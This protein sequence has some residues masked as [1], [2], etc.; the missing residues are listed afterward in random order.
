MIK[1]IV[2]DFDGT[3]VDSKMVV[4]S[5]YNQI[6]AKYNYKLIDDSNIEH[7]K[8]LS[9]MDRMK[10]VNVPLYKVP[11]LITEFFALYQKQLHLIPFVSG[12]ERVL[13]K[14]K[15]LRFKLAVVSSN[16][17]K[18]IKAFLESKGVTNITGVYCSSKIFGKEKVLRRFLIAN[19]LHPS[20]VL[21]VCDE[22]RDLIACR[23]VN[24]KTIWVSWGYD[25][26]ESFKGEAMDYV[27]D[28]PEE[29]MT[30]LN[31]HAL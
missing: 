25:I 12:M 1:Y 3:L 2:F 20:E 18:T 28:S 15:D 26:K 23:K 5:V 24:I 10:A 9:M 4:L 13:E 19:K 21:Y 30:I 22:L 6:A 31:A 7:L 29:L 8:T 16:S 11:F 14:I 27:A 17:S